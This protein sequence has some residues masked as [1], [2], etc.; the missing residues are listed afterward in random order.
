MS[1]LFGLIEFFRTTSSVSG[2]KI[3]S[4]G[5]II[6]FLNLG[7]ALLWCIW[8]FGFKISIDNEYIAYRDGFFR[9]SKVNLSDIINVRIMHIEIN[10]MK[11]P[12]MI[13]STENNK[14]ALQINIKPFS[15]HDIQLVLK[16][17]KKDIV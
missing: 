2:E 9:T 8:L 1:I 17:L 6:F 13:V 7:I 5:M 3:V 10:N 12:R 16:K 14:R 4:E 11:V 15:R